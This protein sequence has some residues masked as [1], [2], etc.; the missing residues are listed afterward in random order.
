[1]LCCI[2]SCNFNSCFAV[3]HTCSC[4]YVGHE[5]ESESDPANKFNTHL[6]AFTNGLITFLNWQL[7]MIE[8]NEI[9]SILDPNSRMPSFG[10]CITFDF[11]RRFQ[12]N[13]L[14][15]NAIINGIILAFICQRKNKT[16]HQ[17]VRMMCQFMWYFISSNRSSPF[18]SLIFWKENVFS[19]RNRRKNWINKSNLRIC[20]LIFFLLNKVWIDTNYPTKISS[21]WL[22]SN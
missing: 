12:I 11:F 9:N 8:K 10:T 13:V 22:F 14:K 7:W 19:E 16:T 18:I 3:L 2:L 21:I 5:Y 4:Q 15:I 17:I 6:C 1:M 20:A